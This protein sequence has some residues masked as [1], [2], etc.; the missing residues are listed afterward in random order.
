M[1]LCKKCGKEFE[2]IK[3]LI[4][5]CSLECRNSRDWT[6]EDKKKKSVSAKNSEKLKKQLNS[7]RTE[8]V[9]DKIVKT[10]KQ[11]HIKKILESNYKDLSFESLRFRILYE[12]ENKCNHCGLDKWLGKDIILELEH[13]DGNNK[14][15]DRSN[16]EMICPNCHSLTQT[17]RGRNKRE[18]RHRVPDKQLLESLLVNDWNM[19]QALLD[20]GLSPKGGNYKR[21]HKL[22]KEYF[23]VV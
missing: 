14:N 10:K 1:K 23:G 15:N 8:E 4:N 19:R 21:C 22:K 17:W 7:I 2:P 18:R 5:Y 3:G 12:Q 11:N 9:Y 13:K 20:V 16:L 6:E